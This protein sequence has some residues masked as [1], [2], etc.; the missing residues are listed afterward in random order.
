[1]R[2]EFIVEYRGDDEGGNGDGRGEV[3]GNRNGEGE[4]KRDGEDEGV[5][6]DGDIESNG[7]PK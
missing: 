5:E 6:G 3:D 1:L 7:S 2:I 4:G